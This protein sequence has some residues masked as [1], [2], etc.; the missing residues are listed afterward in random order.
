MF[1]FLEI[2][3]CSAWQVETTWLKKNEGLGISSMDKP[4]HDDLL[5]VISYPDGKTLVFRRA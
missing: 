4:L 3:F 1:T 5:G 2:I